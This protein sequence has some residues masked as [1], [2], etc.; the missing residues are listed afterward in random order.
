MAQRAAR[1]EAH[2]GNQTTLAAWRTGEDMDLMAVATVRKLHRREARETAA[3]H[4]AA[5][6][7][8]AADAQADAAAEAARAWA[9]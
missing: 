4:K 9:A 3:I 2:R 7:R 8:A 6:A 1:V 5:A